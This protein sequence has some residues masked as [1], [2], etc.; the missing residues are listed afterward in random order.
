MGKQRRRYAWKNLKDRLED[1]FKLCSG[2]EEDKIPDY[3]K[4]LEEVKEQRNIVIDQIRGKSNEQAKCALINCF[5]NYRTKTATGS[6][7]AKKS[8]QRGTARSSSS[9]SS[10]KNQ[11]VKKTSDALSCGSAWEDLIPAPSMPLYHSATGVQAKP[12]AKAEQWAGTT[13]FYFAGVLEAGH[14]FD[15]LIE[16]TLLSL[17]LIVRAHPKH[18]EQLEQRVVEKLKHFAEIGIHSN[19]CIEKHK[20][21]VISSTHQDAA[22]APV[23][24]LFIHLDPDDRIIPGHILH[25]R[26]FAL[27]VQRVPNLSMEKKATT[28]VQIT[29]AEPIC[30]ELGLEAWFKQINNTAA[31]GNLR[32]L[33]NVLKGVVSGTPKWTP[34]DPFLRRDRTLR[35]RGQEIEEGRIAAGFT[36]PNTCVEDFLATSGNQGAIID[37]RGGAE[38][39]EFG[40]TKIK[41]PPDLGMKQVLDKI[42]ALPQHQ[43]KLVKGVVPSFKGYAIRVPKEAEAEMTRTLAPEAAEEQGSALGMIASA[44]WEIHGVPRYTTKAVV[45]QTF[46]GKGGNWT[47]WVIR[48][49]KT[50]SPPRHERA[51]W[52][53]E[54]AEPPPMRSLTINGRDIIQIK[55][56]VEQ[57]K[58]PAKLASWY[59]TKVQSS[60]SVWADFLDPKPVRLDV[61]DRDRGKENM[62][63]DSNSHTL[64][65][66]ADPM[67]V[68]AIAAATKCRKRGP[69]ED[70]AAMSEDVQKEGKSE[71]NELIALLKHQAE[72]ARVDAQKKDNVIDSLLAQ[73]ATLTEQ[74]AA[75]RQDIAKMQESATGQTQMQAQ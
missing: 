3:I 61:G 38:M 57:Q 59:T 66:E 14:L 49:L 21:T 62:Q 45:H 31:K 46:A 5:R 48:P 44:K 36:V 16:E 24:C 37:L 74:V 7:E 50:I 19:A 10:S 15:K 70:I 64:G 28:E 32:E 75:L 1:I 54:A 12:V 39:K 4:H 29:I 56:H 43:R 67:E 13:G 41:M 6:G 47:G 68:D 35:W 73:I 63:V 40:Y 18:N 26:N 53:V 34:G 25:E 55:N 9:S 2:L 69:P 30:R 8:K 58:I 65:Q 72:Q 20:I 60:P 11:G 51:V 22:E 33:K 23:E 17:T 42:K 71:E 27:Q 52:L